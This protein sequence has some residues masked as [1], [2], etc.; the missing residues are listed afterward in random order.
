MVYCESDKLD[1]RIWLSQLKKVIRSQN[2][3][4]DEARLLKNKCA[5]SMD[6]KKVT[7][8]HGQ[9]HMT[10]SFDPQDAPHMA[11][12]HY[13]PVVFYPEVIGQ[14]IEAPERHGQQLHKAE[15]EAANVLFQSIVDDLVISTD[16]GTSSHAFVLTDEWEPLVDKEEMLH[17]CACSMESFVYSWTRPS[18]CSG[19]CGRSRR[20]TLGCFDFQILE[21]ST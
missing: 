21:E 14:H 9:R 13:V 20:I 2:I 18:S 8:Q 17:L 10:L 5:S 4:F 11:T 3:V 7:F 1:Y 19:S 16:V 6:H 15:N 12:N